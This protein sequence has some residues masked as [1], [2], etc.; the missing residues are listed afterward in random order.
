MKKLFILFG[1]VAVLFFGACSGENNSFLYKSSN[2]NDAKRDCLIKCRKDGK[3][4]TRCLE[5]CEKVRGMCE[6]VKTKGCLQDCNTR[7]GK[8]TPASEQCKKRCQGL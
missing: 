7:H 6:A 3:G 4:Q 5:E 1:F 8:N 2:C